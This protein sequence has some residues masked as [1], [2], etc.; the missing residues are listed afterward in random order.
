[1]NLLYD[2][3]IH[4]LVLACYLRKK[5]RKQFFKRFGEGFPEKKNDN[6]PLIWV[7]AVSLGETRAVVPLLRELKKNGSNPRI[8]LTTVTA[9]GHSEGKR[10]FPEADY[11]LYLPFDLPY[12]IKP[13]IKKV[14]PDLVLLV[15]TDFW[16]HLQQAAKKNGAQ[17][18]LVNG[19]ISA[20][21]FRRFSRMPR[22]SRALFS[23]IDR[24]CLQ[25]Q[26][27]A[28]RFLQLGIPQEKISLTGNIKLDGLSGGKELDIALEPEDFVVTLGS[29]HAP[30][31][32]ILLAAI[33]PLFPKF[34]HLKI[35]LVPRHPERFEEVRKL[36]DTLLSTSERE[37]VILV[38]KMG[39]LRHCYSLSSL[40]FVGGTFTSKVGGHNICEPAYYGVPVL[41]GPYT[42]SQPDLHDLVQSHKAGLQV[43][44]K[45]L[46]ETL[47]TL[48]SSAE[49]R[50]ELGNNGQ[51]LVKN[52]S[53]AVAATVKELS[54][55]ASK[56][57]T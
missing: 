49:K 39:V 43:T 57:L 38:D 33:K 20:H 5:S 35:L 48:L 28:D 56:P 47:S 22:F 27:Y 32:K 19:K 40:A 10:A 18:V 17:V 25:G 36:L 7:H 53:G 12:L 14:A 8:L 9:T 6:R 31:E 46:E 29:T 51:T 23:T 52:S 15:E 41:Y 11:H 1:M 2:I 34:P 16:L 30:E 44:T 37:R 21:S 45:E 3:A 13:L 42:F 26:I 50:K 54:S 24:F 55:L 4:L